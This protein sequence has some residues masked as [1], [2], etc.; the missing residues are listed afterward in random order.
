[1]KC[2]CVCI[3]R[4]IINVNRYP[5]WGTYIG[6]AAAGVVVREHVVFCKLMLLFV[7]CCK[8]KQIFEP[9]GIRSNAYIVYKISLLLEQLV[10]TSWSV[11]QKCHSCNYDGL[12]ELPVAELVALF[13]SLWRNSGL[14]VVHSVFFIWWNWEDKEVCYFVLFE[15]LG[16]RWHLN[17]AF[18]YFF[19]DEMF[20]YSVEKFLEL[21]IY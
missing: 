3:R 11:F 17:E 7:R 5:R 20:Q 14:T 4:K 1:M 12:C 18:M 9:T 2:V 6:L 19:F 21:F 10:D 15:G 13:G 8:N 16:M